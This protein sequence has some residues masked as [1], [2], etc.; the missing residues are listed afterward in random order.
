MTARPR[1][2]RGTMSETAHGGQGATTHE[3]HRHHRRGAHRV[4][5]VRRRAPRHLSDGPRRRR[6]EGGAREVQGRSEADRSRHLRQRAADIGRR[7]LLRPA[8][9][10]AVRRPEGGPRAHGEPPLWLGAAGDPPRRAGDPA[11]PGRLRPRRRGG[12]HVDGAAP[13]PRRALGPAARRAEARGLS[14]GRAR[15]LVQRSRHGEHGREPGSEIRDHAR[16]RRRV[17][18][19]VTPAG[20][21][22]PRILPLLGGDRPCRGQGQEGH[23]GGRQGRAHP[24]GHHSGEA[25]V[26]SRAIRKE[27]HGHGR[28]RQRHQ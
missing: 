18:V 2:S 12:E 25:C 6:R 26:L 19:P 13:D 8:H 15:R 16:G 1:T 23:R 27:R 24:G 17:C 28:Q 3:R 5:Y 20:G 4:R 21:E 10:L 22:G 11:R 14:L 7:R 9:R